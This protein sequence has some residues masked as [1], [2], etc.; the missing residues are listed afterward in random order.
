MKFTVKEPATLIEFLLN[1]LH[2]KSRTG[3]KSLLSRHLV[4]VDQTTISRHDY[5]LKTGQLVSI[6]KNQPSS[7]AVFR[8]LKILFE[9]DDLIVIEKNA[10]LLSVA[11]DLGTEKSA[12]SILSAY[13]KRAHAKAKL[14][15]VHRLDR[16]TSGVMMFVKKKE[17]QILLREA[18]QKSIAM[19]SY[20]AIVEGVVKKDKDVIVSW[21]KG[22]D[23][24]RTYTSE[25]S[26]EGQKAVSRY[27]VIKRS[28]AYTLV[29]V[30]LETGRKNQIRIHMQDLGHPVVGDP[31]Y[32]AT[33][34]P[35]GRLGLH[36]RIL[37][38]TH[39]ASGESMRFESKIPEIFLEL[40]SE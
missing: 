31:K 3:V 12:H 36:A 13:V 1:V 22:T 34:D 14:Y 8:E 38:F 35:L 33:K 11:T 7:T 30:E 29:D 28:A 25:K 9:D 20:S 27:T 26:G 4:E 23:G 19:R 21:L 40:F 18:W 2:G 24:L 37:A 6:R 39:P 16:E 32:G 17:L 15:I 10:G 5:V